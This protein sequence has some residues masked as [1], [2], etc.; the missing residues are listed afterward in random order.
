[1]RIVSARD[2]VHRIPD[3]ARVV[4]PHGCVE[5][6][7][8]YDALR[9]EHE[10][11]RRLRLYSGLQFGAYPFLPE[12]IG[13]RWTY[14]TWQASPK[15][16]RLFLER[17]ADFLP[18][19][20][21]DVT[22]VVS[23]EGPVPPDVVVVQVSPPDRGHV[24]LGISVS[25]YR[26]LT[27]QVP[28][29]IAEINPHMPATYG[30]ARLPVDTIDCAIES[31][32]PLGAYPVA[33]RTARDTRI[34][35]HVL[36]LIPRGA[37][38]QFG[39]GAVPDAV[40]G[41]LHEVPD[42]NIHS[43]M[44]TDGLIDF[45]THSRHRARVVTGEVAGS[46]ALYEFVGRTAQVEFHPSRVTHDLAPIAALPRFVSVNSAVEVDLTGQVNGE[47]VDGVQISGVGGSLDFVEGA[48]ASP[49]GLAILAL[50]ST[51]ED[52]RHSKIVTRLA[53]HTPVTIPR[54]CTEYVVTEYGVARLK[55]KT[56]RERAAALVAIAH[57]DFRDGLADD[58]RARGSAR[59]P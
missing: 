51:T 18:I 2:A 47:T 17:R 16:R 57:P 54:Y 11:F 14:T 33:R 34:V 43:G 15:L 35:E 53:A 52:G 29:V 42:T 12:D 32:A 4:L 23:R 19:R 13:E 26:D 27:A 20:F 22:R 10:R 37:W 24:S 30:N 55:G 6:T 25:L 49:G 7:A 3:G 40:L 28:L 58:A 41:R 38:V 46:A 36:G 59:N 21:R 48:A 31:D 56:L 9:A 5:P 1:M 39:V 8:F 44:L 45:V 50:P